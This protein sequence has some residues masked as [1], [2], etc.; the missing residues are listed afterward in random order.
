MVSYPGDLTPDQRA[1]WIESLTAAAERRWGPDRALE[2]E[3]TLQKTAVAIGRLEPIEFTPTDYPAFFLS[4]I[5]PTLS[6]GADDV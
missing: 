6:P 1:S 4:D 3:A 5:Q 2:I